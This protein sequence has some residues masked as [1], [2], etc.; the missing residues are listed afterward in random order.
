MIRTIERLIPMPTTTDP[1]VL[2]YLGLLDEEAPQDD[3]GTT[4][5]IEGMYTQSQEEAQ[6][7]GLMGSQNSKNVS[8]YFAGRDPQMLA[9]LNKSGAQLGTLHGKVADTSAVQDFANTIGNQR[10][11]LYKVEQS[12]R[13]DIDKKTGLRLNVLKYLQDRIDKKE[14]RYN[15]RLSK[16]GEGELKRN[17]DAE[18][19]GLDRQNRMDMAKEN[20][21]IKR[22]NTL[23]QQEMNSRYNNIYENANKL[24]D[25]YKDGNSFAP[26]SEANA[27]A[28]MY[29]HQIA[30]DQSKIAD[31][32][33][34]AMQGEVDSNLR[35]LLN[36]KGDYNQRSNQEAR[37]MLDR[38]LESL[39][40]RIQNNINAKGLGEESLPLNYDER[41]SERMQRFEPD[42]PKKF[43]GKNAP[44][45]EQNPSSNLPI[46]ESPPA[47][48]Q[49]QKDPKE[50]DTKTTNI[51]EYTRMIERFH[52][53][54][55]IVE[56]FEVK[57]APR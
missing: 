9:S 39:E 18:Q 19:G 4:E 56:D 10:D 43:Q 53:G 5:K 38:Y 27:R 41:K 14:D 57:A 34:A 26:G 30:V 55:W 47:A 42:I 37:K 23:S 48:P 7:P 31:P 44:Q 50:G 13:A 25:L 20:S 52:D 54:K 35:G 3:F 2:K 24:R 17:F 6:T 45:I 1:R 46:N 8:D 16:H 15:D 28:N 29:L 51:D 49:M 12:Q 22:A 33:S 21:P 40:R 36:F 32:S 11:R